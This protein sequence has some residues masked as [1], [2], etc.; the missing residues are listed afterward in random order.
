MIKSGETLA[1]YAASEKYRGK[2]DNLFGR[3]SVLFLLGR[4]KGYLNTSESDIREAMPWWRD[5][6]KEINPDLNDVI[7]VEPNG[8]KWF[9]QMFIDLIK[10]CKGYI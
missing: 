6:I 3:S 1:Y 7:V 5:R 4:F 8:Q 9:I 2:I 10:I